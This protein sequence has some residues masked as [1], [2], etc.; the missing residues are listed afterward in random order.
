MASLLNNSKIVW[1]LTAVITFLITQGLKW[2]LIKPYTKSLN[3]RTKTIINSIILIIAFGVAVLCEYLYSHFW[4]KDIINF[5]R[6]FNGWGGASL[7]YSFFE[8]ILKFIKGENVK[9]ENPFKTEEGQET[10]ATVKSVIADGKINKQDKEIA[11]DFYNK[12]NSVK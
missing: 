8:M 2:V 12:L 5:D 10:V 7:V 1:G 9:V 6:A 4:L 3:K 11:K